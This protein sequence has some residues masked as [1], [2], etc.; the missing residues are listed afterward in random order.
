M[1]VFPTPEDL[2]SFLLE[3]RSEDEYVLRRGSV[4]PPFL[5]SDKTVPKLFVEPCFGFFLLSDCSVLCCVCLD[6]S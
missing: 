1:K 5:S 2:W 4:A 3:V 6:N